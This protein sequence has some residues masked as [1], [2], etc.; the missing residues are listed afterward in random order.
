MVTQVRNRGWGFETGIAS[1]G[2]TGEGKYAFEF[3]LG[4]IGIIQLGWC[5]KNVVVNERG[6]YGIGG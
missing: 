6:G 2:V 1:H 4:T 5:S 3:Q